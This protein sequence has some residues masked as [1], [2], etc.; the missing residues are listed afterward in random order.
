MKLLALS[1]VLIAL[2][3]CASSTTEIPSRIGNGFS[4]NYTYADN[5]GQRRIDLSYTNTLNKSVCLGPES[6]P[7]NGVLLGDGTRV[8]LVIEQKEFYLRAEQDYC[9]QCNIL[10]EPGD[11]IAGH[12]DYSS[13][14]LTR[15][16]EGK[17]KTLSFQ[18]RGFDCA[19]MR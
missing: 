19:G 18:P 17:S 12:L 2:F 14:G 4:I 6:W 13:F 15:M 16:E 5:V 3:G 11:V 10:V 1:A 8:Y 9:P 7:S